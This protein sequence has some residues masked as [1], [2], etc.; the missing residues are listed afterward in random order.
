MNGRRNPTTSQQAP[1]QEDL[2][3]RID[4]L[5]REYGQTAQ[6]HD[7]AR[8][9]LKTAEDYAKYASRKRILFE[10]AD[11]HP[12]SP[13]LGAVDAGGVVAN[14]DDDWTTDA[15]SNR[16]DEEEWLEES[17]VSLI[18]MLDRLR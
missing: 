1:S 7:H 15:V 12:S 13:T 18:E 6:L 11:G 17:L 14:S 2:L 16:V 9:S 3:D 8:V 10:G 5:L 4:K